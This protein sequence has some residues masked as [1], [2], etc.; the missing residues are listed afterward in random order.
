MAGGDR[1]LPVMAS[2]T[3]VL[4][5]LRTPWDRARRRAV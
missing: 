3:A 4:D 5:D 2:P 1:E